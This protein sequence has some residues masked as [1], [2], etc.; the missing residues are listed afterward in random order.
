MARE[1]VFS[2]L[3]FDSS[4]VMSSVIPSR[5]YSSSFTPLRFSK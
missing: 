4:V 2:S 5:K 3:I 1:N